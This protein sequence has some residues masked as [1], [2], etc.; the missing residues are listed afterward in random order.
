MCFNKE[1]NQNEWG[2]T[3]LLFSLLWKSEVVG[4]PRAIGSSASQG[5]PRTQA[6]SVY[7]TTHLL[8]CCLYLQ[9]KIG[10]LPCFHVLACSRSERIGRRYVAWSRNC[11]HHHFHAQL[12]GQNLVTWHMYLT[13]REVGKF[14]STWT[15][16]CPNRT[17]VPCYSKGE[18][19]LRNN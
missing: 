4:N 18:G 13:V 11:T 6:P 12:C 10:S 2:K 8:R 7:V 14:T 9:G 16:L 19:I 17:S 15:I 3:V 1:Q 5:H